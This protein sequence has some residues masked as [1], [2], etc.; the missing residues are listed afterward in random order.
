MLYVLVSSD[1]D[2]ISPVVSELVYF[3]CLLILVRKPFYLYVSTPGKVI[4]SLTVNQQPLGVR[5]LGW[6]S[7]EE[8]KDGCPGAWVSL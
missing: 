4:L 8:V 5:D 1:S 6:E 3:S 7:G 2:G